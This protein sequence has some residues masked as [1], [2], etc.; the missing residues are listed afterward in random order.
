MSPK[1]ILHAHK[2]LCSFYLLFLIS[3]MA[4]SD[5]NFVCFLNTCYDFENPKLSCSSNQCNEYLDHEDLL[6]IIVYFD[7]FHNFVSK[8]AEIQTNNSTLDNIKFIRD[9]IF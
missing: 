2:I 6:Q 8:Q 1:S 5:G 7:N 3:G 4:Q 9:S